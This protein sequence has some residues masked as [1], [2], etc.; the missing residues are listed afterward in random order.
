MCYGWSVGHALALPHFPAVCSLW[1]WLAAAVG[2]GARGCCMLCH[3]V[4][5]AAHPAC[6]NSSNPCAAHATAATPGAGKGGAPQPAKYDL[7]ANI[8][9]EGKAGEGVYKVHVHRKVEDIW[10]EVQVRGPLLRCSSL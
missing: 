7:V 3:A 1:P 8:V 6:M 4:L 5:P 10:Y 2:G 9:H